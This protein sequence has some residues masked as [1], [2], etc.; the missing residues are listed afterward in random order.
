MLLLAIFSI[1]TGCS[2]DDSRA[3][4]NGAAVALSAEAKA[5]IAAATDI[6]QLTNENVVVDYVKKTK[7]LPNYYVTKA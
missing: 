5:Q 4:L 3:D 1:F 7:K 2:N 6:Y